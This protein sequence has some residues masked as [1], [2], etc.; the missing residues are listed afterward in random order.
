MPRF[1]GTWNANTNEPVLADGDGGEDGDFYIVSELGRTLLDGI[2]IWKRADH[3]KMVEGVWT[4]VNNQPL[5]PPVVSQT[6]TAGAVTAEAALQFGVQDD[7]GTQVMVVDEIVTLTNAVETNLAHTVPAGAVILSVQGNLETL[8]VGDA[9]GDNLCAKVGIG[10]TADPDKY[11]ISA[12]L[13]ANLKINTL[14]DWAVLGSAETVTVKAAK[15]DGSACTEKF[16]AGGK[17]RV[18][19]VYLKLTSLANA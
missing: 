8:V 12:A 19:I 15:T 7:E 1:L 6:L 2:D 18:R 5:D 4:R 17:V 3:V 14:P 9:S 16:V 13:T 11:G 10:V